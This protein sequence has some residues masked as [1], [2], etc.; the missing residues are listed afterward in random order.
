M[1]EIPQIEV[2]PE[3]CSGC[4]ICVAVCNYDA[5]KLAQSEEGLTAVIDEL[6]CKRCGACSAAC[7]SDAITI[8]YY[9]A[10]QIM[11]EIE[12]VLV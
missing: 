8:E 6:R 1:P 5:V 4:G 2:N 7:P 11:S 3:I 9:S 10:Q 12:E